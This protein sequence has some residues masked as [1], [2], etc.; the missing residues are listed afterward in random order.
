MGLGSG[1]NFV[2][3]WSRGFS[4]PHVR[5]DPGK[6]DFGPEEKHQIYAMGLAP[7]YGLILS[8]P[9]LIQLI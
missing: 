6:F 7:E 8:I 9:A 5:N 4:G 2:H 1:T 3:H